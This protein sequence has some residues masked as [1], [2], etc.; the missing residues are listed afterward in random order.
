MSLILLNVMII[1]PDVGI[2]LP[3]NIFLLLNLC[4]F[5]IRHVSSL[6]LINSFHQLFPLP[7]TF[8]SPS[9]SSVIHILIFLLLS[10]INF[11]FSFMLSFMPPFCLLRETLDLTFQL[12]NLFLRRICHFIYLWSSSFVCY[13]FPRF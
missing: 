4:I 9:G 8:T 1:C 2:F 13:I 3:V 5:S 11:N 10:S 6:F 7:L 12:I